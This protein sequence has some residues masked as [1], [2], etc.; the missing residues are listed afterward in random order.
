M[1]VKIHTYLMLLCD[2]GIGELS[3]SKTVTLSITDQ[4]D[5]PVVLTPPD[6][7]KI[8]EGYKSTKDI[9]NIISDPDDDNLTLTVRS[10][11]GG[12]LPGWIT[13][14]NTS[15]LISATPQRSEIGAFNLDIT[16]NDGK[17]GQVILFHYMFYQ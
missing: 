11:G 16:G 4:N 15:N 5:A 13:F 10:S 17:G 1:K 7:W 9:S 12:M 14:D 2:D 8:S 3:G 6:P